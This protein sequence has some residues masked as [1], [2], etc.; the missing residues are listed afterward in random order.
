MDEQLHQ[1]AHDGDLAAL[2]RLISAGADINAADDIGWTPLHFA[3]DNGNAPIIAKLLAK[4]ASPWQR[5]N[6]G[7]APEDRIAAAPAGKQEASRVA[8]AA[9]RAARGARTK[10]A[11]G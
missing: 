8:Y 9:Y 4:G 3:C 1:A 5:D 7:C 10:P 2:Q 11:R 6:A